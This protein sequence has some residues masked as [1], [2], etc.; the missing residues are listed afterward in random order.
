MDGRLLEETILKMSE[1][2]AA[3]KAAVIGNG[4]KSL[5]KQIEEVRLD[6]RS[7]HDALAKK[8]GKA[9]AFQNKWVGGYLALS[10]LASLAL[11]GMK[12]WGFVKP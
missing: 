9:S 11:L 1:D 12:V 3:L 6:C 7:A 10:G 8:A 5:Y 2:V 4:T